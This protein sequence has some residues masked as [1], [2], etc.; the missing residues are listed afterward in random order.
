MIRSILSTTALILLSVFSLRAGYNPNTLAKQLKT[1]YEQLEAFNDRNEREGRP[2]LN[3][4]II[5]LNPDWIEERGSSWLQS[6]YTSLA[7]MLR[8]FNNGRKD[9]LRFYVVAVFGIGFPIK[10]DVNLQKLPQVLSSKKYYQLRGLLNESDFYASRDIVYRN[11]ETGIGIR[12]DILDAMAA[13]G[14]TERVLYY[15]TEIQFYDQKGENRYYSIDHLT[16]TGALLPFDK[17]IRSKAHQGWAHPDD[18]S[19]PL[20]SKGLDAGSRIKLSVTNLITAIGVEY[21]A[22]GSS[23]TGIVN[24]G[25]DTE[26]AFTRGTEYHN[27]VK[28]MA[29]LLD[30]PTGE[31]QVNSRFCV[32][33]KP[34][35]FK[36]PRLRD[37]VLPDVVFNTEI[38]PDKLNLLEKKSDYRM[39]V[40]FKEVP[41]VIPEDKREE[42]A[43]AVKAQSVVVAQQPNAVVIVVPY[44][45]CTD[46]EIYVGADDRNVMG[47][48]VDQEYV[49]PML[50]MPASFGKSEQMNLLMNA[51]L[52]REKSFRS[53]FEQ[54]FRQIPKDH[55]T[56]LGYLLWN[57]QHIYKEYPEK[58]VAGF[59]NFADVQLLVDD[60]M[61]K[62]MPYLNCYQTLENDL[63]FVDPKLNPYRDRNFY[64]KKYHK[65][66]EEH[67]EAIGKILSQQPVVGFKELNAGLCTIRQRILAGEDGMLAAMNYIQA[68]FHSKGVKFWV[69]N[70]GETTL[71]DVDLDNDIFY[72][73][74]N[75]YAK[76][77]WILTAIDA[78]SFLA[79]FVGLDFIFDAAG[80]VVCLVI[81]D[82]NGAAVYA[83]SIFVPAAIIKSW[84]YIKEVR[85]IGS[86]SEEAYK[87]SSKSGVV[88]H[89]PTGPVVAQLGGSVNMVPTAN[90]GT[91]LLRTLGIADDEVLTMA[92]SDP[93]VA[94][95]LEES[96]TA[97]QGD[98]VISRPEQQIQYSVDE[99]KVKA[100]DKAL[101]KQYKEARRADPSL[102]FISFLRQIEPKVIFQVD[103]VLA[104]VAKHIKYDPDYFYVF[105]HGTEYDGFALHLADGTGVLIPHEEVADWLVLQKNFVDAITKEGKKI[106]LI[107]CCAAANRSAQDLSARLHELSKTEGSSIKG[108]SPLI[109]APD[110]DY[111]V[112]IRYS[113]TGTIE[114]IEEGSTLP[115]GKWYAYKDGKALGP[116]KKNPDIP[117][118]TGKINVLTVGFRQ[119]P[120]INVASL[121]RDAD[122]LT[123]IKRI[124]PVTGWFDVVVHATPDRFWVLHNGSWVGITHRDLFNYLKQFPAF[125]EAQ[126]VRLISCEAGTKELA[127][128]FANKSKKNVRAV[129]GSRIGVAGNGDVVSLSGD[130]HWA[131]FKK[132]EWVI[133]FD[134]ASNV[135]ASYKIRKATSADDATS[136]G[137][138]DDAVAELPVA[139]RNLNF[140]ITKFLDHPDVIKVK[141]EIQSKNIH[142]AYPDLTVDELTAIRLYS[143]HSTELNSKL[144][145][146]GT[147]DEYHKG[148]Y[149]LLNSGREKLARPLAGTFYSGV[150]GAG[151]DKAMTWE[152]GDNVSQPIVTSASVD[153]GIAARFTSDVILQIKNPMGADIAG[154]ASLE[155]KEILI[156]KGYEF[157]VT[158]IEYNV[159]F[160]ERVSGGLVDHGKS[161]RKIY[162]E[163]SSA[164]S[165]LD[166]N[167]YKF[168]GSDA[169]DLLKKWVNDAKADNDQGLLKDLLERKN[170]PPGQFIGSSGRQY[171]ASLPNRFS[172]TEKEGVIWFTEQQRAQYEIVVKDGKPYQ[173]GIRLN[174][175]ATDPNDRDKYKFVMASNGK[176]YGAREIDFPGGGLA[177][178]S[179]LGKD[180]NVV[181]AGYL[182]VDG[183]KLIIEN[184]SGHFHPPIESLKQMVRELAARGVD[185]KIIDIV[186][187]D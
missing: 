83:A 29:Q 56:Y 22:K 115:N 144:A 74:K 127:Q 102:E 32:V 61:E 136:L 24:C 28:S 126:G 18:P 4:Y 67:G 133:S 106:K 108:A 109:E 21:D 170:H 141:N 98:V 179:F 31:Q 86:L 114:L 142:Q 154:I 9:N 12:N 57:G 161:G 71:E 20:A 38:L 156:Q 80:G 69:S 147:L 85:K 125:V 128:N 132:D 143:N 151:V 169:P 131:E 139:Y 120:D 155:E 121:G 63:Q 165:D 70:K 16:V 43:Q 64:Y 13:K 164:V 48:K 79:S 90:D 39:Y 152:L 54:A 10:K 36:D 145:A 15:Y 94:K 104:D 181:T 33:D 172:Q 184:Y 148:F 168:N 135:P 134:H 87:L 160:L 60:R 14:H 68:S 100:N 53:G 101:V 26:R 82:G 173:N 122:I 7:N 185:I 186:K 112:N 42:F 27:A 89:T 88:V 116:I 92:K 96:M 84:K 17:K 97:R 119:V 99:L 174:E 37:M 175:G 110:V 2:E 129:S 111:G 23:T 77:P 66:L 76:K 46:N 146:G 78:G 65:C 183:G 1:K 166:R 6:E 40:V 62:I 34:N 167:I 50:L 130:G 52:I 95:A 177:H 93:S 176:I 123:S 113:D 117:Q 153:P 47:L 44:Y 162:L 75:P 140:D 8:G 157:T 171:Q 58:R 30:A 163:P 72:G 150:S 49:Y 105:I 11:D 137:I 41:F 180:V 59:S 81:D 107:S 118:Y 73:N 35:N 45:S 3:Q 103:P 5:E 158:N 138:F 19:F 187:R 51:A 178:S 91:D 149:H 124:K 55:M 159:P 25:K 182:T